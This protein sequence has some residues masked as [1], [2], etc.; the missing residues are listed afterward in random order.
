VRTFLYI[1]FILLFSGLSGVVHADTLPPL[2]RGF[3]I[4]RPSFGIGT[5][6]APTVS[7]ASLVDRTNAPE[8]FG[9]FTVRASDTIGTIC[10]TDLDCQDL[11]QRINRI[12]HWNIRPGT[13][14]LVPVEM[15]VASRYVPV[16]K[17]AARIR[18]SR[19]I[20]V[21]IEQQYFGAYENGALLFW[22]PVSTHKAGQTPIGEFRISSKDIDHRSSKYGN[23]PMPYA[24]QLSQR[25][26]FL[27]QGELPG[28]PASHGCI[29]LLERDARRLFGWSEMNDP[30]T[31]RR[32]I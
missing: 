7:V 3:V 12:D 32:S 2:G 13:R 9:W 24:M 23:L 18:G 10:G 25:E 21:Y 17:V 16:P 4:G 8:G 26:E 22:G 28:H 27:H 11:F 15:D 30:I 20:I 19:E 29:R 14:V 5:V 1:C 6:S 31:V